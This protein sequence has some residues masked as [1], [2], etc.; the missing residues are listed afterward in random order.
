[1]LLLSAPVAG[2][3]AEQQ[4]L[5]APAQAAEALPSLAPLVDSVKAA[6]VNVDVQSR[7]PARARGGNPLEEFFGG[8]QGRERVQKGQGSGFIVDAR[9]LVVTNN[10]VVEGAVDIRVRLSDGRSFD[11]EVLG[12]D[13]L[14]D[15]AV[16]KLKGKLEKLP[17]VRLGDSDALRVGDW[18][19][20]I[21]N[22]FGLASSVS[23]GIISGRS[24]EIGA[25]NYDEFLQTDAAIN[26]G[27]SGGPLFNLR[28]EV[29]GINTAI[30][31]GGTSVGFAVPS[32]LARAL[33]PQLEKDGRVTR[34]YLG[35]GPQSLTEEL[36]RALGVPASKGAVVA[37]VEKESP[38]A[39]AGIK[40]EDVIVALDGKAVGDDRELTR[41]VALMRPD[42]SIRVTLY[43][44]AEKRDVSVKL[45][46]RPDFERLGDGESRGGR[47]EESGDARVGISLRDMDTRMARAQEMSEQGALVAD[48]KPGSAAERAGLASG[49][50]VIEANRKPV[51]GARDLE[52]VLREAKS[53]ASVLLR[54]EVPGGGT[55]LR[56]LTV[57]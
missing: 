32:N 6:V 23:L 8:P 1:M 44:G 10:H 9:G 12:R 33:L 4:P 42:T 41:T 35:V 57:P 7:S 16:L 47:G 13:P 18:V 11:A 40:A 54:V 37:R 39:K 38:A 56:A 36:A 2:L 55:L 5:R 22:P 30:I 43:R 3:A 21:G 31:G 50:S 48:V 19:M 45:G 20:A 26:P 27:N 14:T 28:G 49:M 15:V 29:I 53:G 51:R 34:G 46:K 52:R 25:S 17:L 24:R